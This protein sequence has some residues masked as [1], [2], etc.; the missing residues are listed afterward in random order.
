MLHST[1]S[2]QD[3]QR[4]RD[5]YWTC[6]RRSTKRKKDFWTCNLRLVALWK[7]KPFACNYDWRNWC[8][9][10][11]KRDPFTNRWWC[12]RLNSCPIP[13]KYWWRKLVWKHIHHWNYESSTRYWWSS[14]KKWKTGVPVRDQTTR[15]NRSQ[16][17]LENPYRSSSKIRIS[18]RRTNWWV[19][20]KIRRT[21]R[22]RYQRLRGQS[23]N[24]QIGWES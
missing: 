18:S 10:P 19:S 21:S 13:F 3:D 16:I 2:L 15:Q 7:I 11:S 1:R 24:W 20:A 4:I 8:S 9:L 5:S 12:Y 17:N 6:W 22:C 23:C 14:F